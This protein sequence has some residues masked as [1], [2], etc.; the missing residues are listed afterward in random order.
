MAMTIR[1]DEW[2]D[3]D[4]DTGFLIERGDTAQLK[5]VIGCLS[6]ICEKSS[7]PSMPVTYTDPFQFF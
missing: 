1:D 5:E 3:D 4:D 7:G 2:Y 6:V